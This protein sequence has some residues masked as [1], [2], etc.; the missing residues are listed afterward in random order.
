MFHLTA[1]QV[2]II[3][4]LGILLGA[5]IVRMVQAEFYNN[6]GD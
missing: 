6:D 5:A 2:M 1:G 3:L 4:M